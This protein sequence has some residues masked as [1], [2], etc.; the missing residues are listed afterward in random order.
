[1]AVAP[2]HSAL[3]ILRRL[4]PLNTLSD[5]GL[6]DLMGQA[7][8]EK[9]KKGDHLFEKG[10]TDHFN[11]YLLNGRLSML[12]NDRE[13]DTVQ[14]GSDTARFPIAHQVPR[15]YTVIAKT[16][17][18]IV[19]ID[20]RLLGELLAKTGNTDYEVSEVA[21][22]EDDDW[23]SQLLNSPVFQQIPAA[24]IQSVMM[25]MEGQEVAAG[26]VIINYGDEGDYFYLI[27]KGRCSI[28]RPVDEQSDELIEIAQLGPGDSFGEEA[29]LS[30]KPR[31]STVAMLSDG[32]LLRLSKEDFVQ[33]VKQPLAHSVSTEQAL[34]LAKKGAVLLD[35][36]SSEEY[37]KHHLS[38]SVSLPFGSLRYQASSLDPDH[39]YIVYCNDGQQSATAA[40]LLTAQGFDVTVLEGGII[41]ADSELVDLVEEPEAPPVDDEQGDDTEKMVAFLK[42]ELATA[43]D[44]VRE[45][46]QQIGNFKLAFDEA[47]ELLGRHQQGEK[48]ARQKI[49]QQQK[50]LVQQKSAMEQ[51][52]TDKDALE[53]QQAAIQAE[54]AEAHA[55]S[56]EAE[57]ADQENQKQQ[58]ALNKALE[59]SKTEQKA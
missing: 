39:Q 38:G 21:G 6:E 41:Q 1:M 37:E 48:A 12:S 57:R 28:Q 59:E 49:Q 26:D 13:V 55:Q 25:R 53:Q 56:E 50:L 36:R 5:A 23:M 29:L 15:K 45:Q 35:V 54:L 46:K 24:N 27:N 10:D 33:F 32:M 40:Y 22:E 2:K 18:E 8:F 31:S 47:K 17:A 7:I 4:V 16:R 51:L 42:R 44:Q 43:Q 34:A 30:G 58:E 9:V 14:A 20:N 11:V 3:D 19:R 52:Q